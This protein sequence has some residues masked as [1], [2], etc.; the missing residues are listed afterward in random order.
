MKTPVQLWLL[1]AMFF[2]RGRIRNALWFVLQL[3]IKL[4]TC[5]IIHYSWICC[6]LKC[7]C[8]L[9]NYILK[10]VYTGEEEKKKVHYKCWKYQLQQIRLYQRLF[11]LCRS[12]RKLKHM[13]DVS[14]GVHNVSYLFKVFFE[15]TT[16][17]FVS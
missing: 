3:L 5:Q 15:A 9:L 4:V 10:I 7:C 8:G 6:V 16:Y 14:L 2:G 1:V 12:I 13:L 17:K 11:L